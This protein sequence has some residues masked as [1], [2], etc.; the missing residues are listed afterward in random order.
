M[1]LLKQSVM[2]P[3]TIPIFLYVLL[4]ESW[5]STHKNKSHVQS[6]T[7]IIKINQ[8]KL[9]HFLSSFH[10]KGFKFIFHKQTPKVKSKSVTRK[11]FFRKSENP[12]T[13]EER[14]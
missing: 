4:R 14:Y 8:E 11:V 7:E 3:V 5:Q 12:T 10:E 1:Q 13:H 6:Q 9:D 2:L